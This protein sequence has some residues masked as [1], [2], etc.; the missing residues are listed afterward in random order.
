MRGRGVLGC[1]LGVESVFVLRRDLGVELKEKNKCNF[2]IVSFWLL[3]WKNNYGIIDIR[4]NINIPI[5]KLLR[6]HQSLRSDKIRQKFG[7]TTKTSF[8]VNFFSFLSSILQLFFFFFFST[9]S[10]QNA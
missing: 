4:Y 8:L 7:P 6:I 2:K 1:L 3:L 5:I 9:S 10:I